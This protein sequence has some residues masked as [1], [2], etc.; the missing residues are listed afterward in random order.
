V[1]R[2]ETCDIYN[3]VVRPCRHPTRDN[4]LR[5]AAL[6]DSVSIRIYPEQ[7]A[8]TKLGHTIRGLSAPDL[9]VSNNDE[10]WPEFAGRDLKRLY[11]PVEFHNLAIDGGT[12]ED[13]LENQ[14]RL[15]MATGADIV[16][17]TVGGNDLLEM[18]RASSPGQITEGVAL[19]SSRYRETVERI[20]SVVPEA[21]VLLTTVYDPTDGTGALPGYPP[22]PVP[23]LTPLNDVIREV[24]ASHP[25]LILA[26][27]FR[28]FLGHG[29]SAPE[30]ERWYWASQMIE[31]SMEGASEV[32]RVWLDSLIGDA[33][34]V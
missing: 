3:R 34:T 9:F 33:R 2:P 16:T 5:Y 19:L 28:H 18:L 6:G 1:T 13:V 27:V 32:R 10:L 12:M 24:A 15:L 20:R 22:L 8:L 29:V 14:V 21:H 17:L 31:P 26:D 30:S 4:P 11:G 23:L 7:D 25:R